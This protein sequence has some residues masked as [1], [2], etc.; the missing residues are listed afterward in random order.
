MKAGQGRAAGDGYRLVV[1]VLGNIPLELTLPFRLVG[2]VLIHL[3]E[4]S[5][6]AGARQV[7]AT[8][9]YRDF[10]QRLLGTDGRQLRL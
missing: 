4:A 1:L 5:V 2:K 7:S 8:R 6:R 3:P 9:A 10:I